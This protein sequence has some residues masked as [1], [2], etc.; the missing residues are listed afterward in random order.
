MERHY[1][2]ICVSL[3][4]TDTQTQGLVTWVDIL[5]YYQDGLSILS[6]HGYSAQGESYICGHCWI[7][8]DGLSILDVHGCSDTDVSHWWRSLDSP[9]WSGY[10]WCTQIL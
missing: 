8:Q 5:R 10:P 7:V 9:G 1:R 3:V 6:V 2:I 4:H